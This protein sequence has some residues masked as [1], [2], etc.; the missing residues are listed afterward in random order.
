[1][2][3]LLIPDPAAPEDT[4][5]LQPFD[6][7][8]AH[9]LARL[10]SLHRMAEHDMLA[11]AV[12]ALVAEL[13]RLQAIE[14]DRCEPDEEVWGKGRFFAARLSRTDSFWIWEKHSDGGIGTSPEMFP[15]LRALLD[16][17]EAL[18]PPVWPP[19]PGLREG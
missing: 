5:R 4:S 11:L 10:K 2:S 14:Q 9:H 3:I 12:P 7:G 15:D 6:P 17:L 8:N 1:M 18:P 19:I 13:Q 16:E